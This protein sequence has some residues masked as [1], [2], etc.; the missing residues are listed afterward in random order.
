[1]NKKK[2]IGQ[3]VSFRFE[4]VN[5]IEIYRGYIIDYNDD[6]TLLKYNTV[7]YIID[8]YIILR[9]KFILSY[10]LDEEERFYKKVLKL[11][12]E[13]VLPADKIP[14]DTIQS[15]LNHLTAKF[16]TFQFDSKSNLYSY[17]GKVKS[18]KKN[19]LTIDS[20]S[21]KGVWAETQD[22]KLGN[23]RTI[24]YD[25]DYLNSLLLVAN[26][27]KKNKKNTVTSSGSH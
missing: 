5:K 13:S 20:L 17:I 23:I 24:Q 2:H 14:I 7:D 18:I 10:R 15:I 3:I 26:Q 21:P 27:K 22:Y 12:G 19:N 6:W 11:K 25:T 4:Y 9:N 1:M 16:G 8:G